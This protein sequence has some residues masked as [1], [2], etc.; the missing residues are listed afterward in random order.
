MA[1]YIAAAARLLVRRPTP[2][3]AKAASEIRSRL[4]RRGHDVL[5]SRVL[6]PSRVST[7]LKI[8]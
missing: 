4:P 2:I 8:R 6:W 3:S 1:D 7:K 5:E